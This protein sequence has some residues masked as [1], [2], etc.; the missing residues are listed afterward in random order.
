MNR[1]GRVVYES[2]NREFRWYAEG[3][4]SGVYFYLLK[5]T[6][7]EFKGVVSVVTGSNSD[8]NR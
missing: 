8:A 4:P 3:E 6:N 5:F 7:R 1:W 2:D